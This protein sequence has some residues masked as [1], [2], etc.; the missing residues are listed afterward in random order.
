MTE[1]ALVS[2]PYGP[3]AAGALAESDPLSAWYEGGERLPYDPHRR[4]AGVGDLRVFVRCE[5]DIANAVTF[6]PG[7]PDGSSGWAQTLAHLPG[8]PEMPKLFVD[9]VGMGDS[10][11]PVQYSYS[12]AE[13]ADLV[14]ALW[15]DLGVRAT[16]LIAFDFSSLVALEHLRRRLERASRGEP[17]G[18]PEIRGVFIFN[19]GLF[20]DGHSHP[21]WTTPLL[22][23]LPRR[24]ERGFEAQSF[25]MFMALAGVMRT[26]GFAGR[27]AAGRRVFD[28]LRRRDGFSYLSRAAGF[29]AD[30]QAQGVRLDF[31][32]L[33]R[34]WRG[35]F[36]FL[37][38]GSVEDVFE[39]R[40]IDLAVA[41]LGSLGLEITRLPGGHMTTDEQP[42][43][44]AELIMRF[45]DAT[46]H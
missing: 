1:A 39:C 18:G 33:F 15:R 28:S 2:S 7:Y 38:G 19:G 29:V 42:R 6:L 43:A 40:Q 11:K 16:T 27:N 20:V 12:T 32:A 10:D 31:G 34:A 41:R 3:A 9:Y 14:E 22:R 17:E 36:P 8:A 13:R 46:A 21:W 26:R 30:H 4:A 37:V 35:R 44:L 25:A 5:G 24:L 23:R 45:V